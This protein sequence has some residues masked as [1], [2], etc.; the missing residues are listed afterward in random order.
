MALGGSGVDLGGGFWGDS[1]WFLE[2]FW[3]LGLIWKDSGRILYGS[4]W[5]EA[6]DGFGLDLEGVG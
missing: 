4:P 6:L 2:S 1:L 3:I 5:I